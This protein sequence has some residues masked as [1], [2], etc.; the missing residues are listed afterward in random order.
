MFETKTDFLCAARC[1]EPA[2]ALDWSDFH[3]DSHFNDLSDRNAKVSGGSFGVALHE[4]VQTLPPVPRVTNSAPPAALYAPNSHCSPLLAGVRDRTMLIMIQSRRPSTLPS[5]SGLP[6]LSRDIKPTKLIKR[7]RVDDAEGFWLAAFDP[8]DTGGLDLDKG[9]AKAMLA[10]D[11]ERLAWLQERLYAY[12]RWALLVVL[13]GMDAAGKDGVIKHVMSGVNPQGCEVYPF[14]RRP[15][16]NWITISSGARPS[17]CRS[18]DTSAFSIVPTTKRCWWCGCTRICWRA[19][20]FPIS[21]SPII[22]GR[23]ALRTFA[24][25][26]AT[27]HVMAWP[28]SVIPSHLQGRATSAPSR[29]ARRTRQAL[30]VLPG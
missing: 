16:R 7:Y 27:S 3:F 18:G 2:R 8:A 21:S 14:K 20:S 26:R 11:I 23:S 28:S 19:R 30:E 9:N 1:A 12:D 29:S 15:R 24:V 13:Q 25:L 17:A 6:E 10:Q 22:S 5:P 4:G